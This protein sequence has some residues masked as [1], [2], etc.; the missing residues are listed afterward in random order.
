MWDRIFP[1]SRSKSEFTHIL[2]KTDARLTRGINMLFWF[3]NVVLLFVYVFRYT[4]KYY[5][6]QKDY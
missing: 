5:K 2:L 1:G 3:Y 4:H 6:K